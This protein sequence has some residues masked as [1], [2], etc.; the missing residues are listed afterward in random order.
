M[1]DYPVIRQHEKKKKKT[2]EENYAWNVSKCKYET[3]QMRKKGGSPNH[4]KKEVGVEANKDITRKRACTINNLQK[5]EKSNASKNQEDNKT[6]E[7]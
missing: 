7:K 4:W 1:L 5:K 2:V 3:Y 6:R